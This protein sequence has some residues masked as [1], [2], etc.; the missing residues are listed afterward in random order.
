MVNP[1]P[2]EAFSI[3][4]MEA[5]SVGLPVV[6]NGR[7]AATREH[8]ERSGGGLWFESYATFEAVVDRLVADARL[9]RIMGGRGRTYV[10]RNFRWPAIIDR[11]ASFVARVGARFS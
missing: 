6:V 8:C 4:L 11:Y 3:V 9:R 7:C 10:E 2:H 5:F 1:S